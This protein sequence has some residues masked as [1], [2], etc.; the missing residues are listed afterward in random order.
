MKIMVLSLE[1]GNSIKI[2]NIIPGTI[3]KYW[4]EIVNAIVEIDAKNINH[5]K[6]MSYNG[7]TFI[8]K[9]LLIEENLGVKHSD[10]IKEDLLLLM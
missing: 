8:G 6:K 7:S 9:N 4:M 2:K 3:L 5:V 10:D 1:N